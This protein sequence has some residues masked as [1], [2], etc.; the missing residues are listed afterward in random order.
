MVALD[1]ILFGQFL[2]LLVQGGHYPWLEQVQRQELLTAGC[3]KFQVKKKVDW[4]QLDH[5][6]VDHK[7]QL[8]YCYVPKVRSGVRK[9]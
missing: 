8:L 9:N 2:V 4:M 3:G 1:K 7:H 6:L 5:I